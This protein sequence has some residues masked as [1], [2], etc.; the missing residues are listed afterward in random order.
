M[1]KNGLKVL[2]LYIPLVGISYV[3]LTFLQKYYI[4]TGSTLNNIFVKVFLLLIF[5][6]YFYFIGKIMGTKSK[7]RFD[8]FS[9]NLVAVV[10][11][12]LFAL[13]AFSD[14]IGPHIKLTAASLPASIFL[15]PYIML[16]IAFNLDI[17]IIFIIS[18]LIITSLIVGISIRRRRIKIRNI[19]RS[20]G[21]QTI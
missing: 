7:A 13:S 9:I 12:F 10:S 3:I 19:R 21:R 5:T 8:F 4:S 17:N 14:G 18:C 16:G 1:I 11:L 6:V 15:S 2:I 20:N